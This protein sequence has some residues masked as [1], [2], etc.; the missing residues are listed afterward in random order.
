[1][2]ISI[3]IPT[4]NVS[5][6]ITD[7]LESIAKQTYKGDIECIIVDD[8]SKDNSVQ[9]IKEYIKQYNGSVTFKLIRRNT[10]G[11]ASATR[12]TGIIQASGEYVMFVDGDDW[13]TS[14]CLEGMIH[15]LE[16]YPNVDM[17]H[18]GIKTTNGEMEQF[19]LETHPLQEYT[20]DYRF[21]KTELIGKEIIPASP[22]NKLLAL[23][24]IRKNNLYFHEGIVMEDVLW[25]NML[26]KNVKSVACLNKNTYIYRIHE[27]SIVTSGLGVDLNRKL[28]VYDLIIKAIDEPYINEQVNFL[29]YRLD[30]VYFET[31]SLETRKEV[32]RISFQLLKYLNTSDKKRMKLKLWCSKFDKG[33]SSLGYY[34]YAM[35]SSDYSY[36]KIAKLTAKRLFHIQ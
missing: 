28:I 10:N 9:I 8:C 34:F 27:G 26:A 24:F 5:E 31:S 3:I 13:I 2:K 11:G 35:L 25:C 7:C 30:R 19:D 18:A 1:M 16:K 4:Y 23:E 14:N 6:Y 32:R 21:I 36:Y 20:D 12:N 22:C 17:I 29:I 15:L 33:N